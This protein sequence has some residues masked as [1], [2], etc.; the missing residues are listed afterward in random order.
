MES[1]QAGDMYRMDSDLAR[2]LR[3]IY[4]SS[5]PKEQKTEKV[6]QLLDLYHSEKST[7][8]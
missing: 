4:L 1:K 3:S 7:Q 5:V 6:L 8:A 2:E